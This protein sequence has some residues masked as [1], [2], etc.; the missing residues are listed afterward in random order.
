[1]EKVICK[2]CVKNM[3]MNFGEQF[4]REEKIKNM[5]IVRIVEKQ[6]LRE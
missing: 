1:M 2:K 5:L 4:I 3:L 6:H